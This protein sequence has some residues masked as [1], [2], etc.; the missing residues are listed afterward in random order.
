MRAPAALA[1]LILAAAGA[2]VSAETAVAARAIPARQVISVDDIAEGT[3]TVPGAATLEAAL[4][5]EARV[6]IFKGQPVLLASLAEPA[7]IERNQLVRLVFSA[8][9]ITIETEGRA[10]DRAA[11]GARVRVL[12]TGSRSVVVGLVRP[13]GAVEISNPN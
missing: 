3:A 4:G 10:L 11:S 12:N 8:R 9:G 7:S 2:P 13:D 1:A 6:T 5:M